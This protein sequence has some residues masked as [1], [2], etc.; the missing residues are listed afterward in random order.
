MHVQLPKPLH[1]WRAFAGEVGIIVIGVLIALGA[2][3]LVEAANWRSEARDFS[4]A[5]DHELG[6]NL[7]TYDV[8]VKQRPCVSRRL[9]ELER[10][11]AESSAGRRLTLQRPIGWP[12]SYSQY[13]SVW[14]NR[15]ADVTAHLPGDL[16]RRYAELY[17]EFANADAV[18]Q[19]ERAVWRELAVYDQPEPLDHGDRMRLRGL[20][21]RA[22]QINNV[23]VTNYDFLLKLTRRLGIHSLD[24]GALTS[25][26]ADADFCRPLLAN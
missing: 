19:N 18:H 6:L 23:T 10:F 4:K 8:T 16:R 20:L 11:L 22:E 12:K 2:Q 3:Q 7:G 5:V 24:E 9:G 25:Q 14:S 13:T 15:G 1:G 17:D 26:P 21:S